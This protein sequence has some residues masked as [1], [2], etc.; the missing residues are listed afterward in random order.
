MEWLLLP[1]GLSVLMIATNAFVLR[2]LGSYTQPR[3]RTPKVSVLVP[4]RNEAVN[5]PRLLPSLLGQDYPNLEIILLDDHS[6]DNT[7]QVAQAH[8]DTIWQPRPTP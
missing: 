5:L 7:L 1:L 4:A 2:S 6:T 3:T 8:A